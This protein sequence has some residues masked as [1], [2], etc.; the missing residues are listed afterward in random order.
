MEELAAAQDAAQSATAQQGRLHKALHAAKQ[1]VPCLR[2]LL[3]HRLAG[4]AARDH[5]ELC[6]ALMRRAPCRGTCRRCVTRRWRCSLF[7]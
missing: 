1:Q 4:V 2:A 3:Q 5:R 6:A 7:C